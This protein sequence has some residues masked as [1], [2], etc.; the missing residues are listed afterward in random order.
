[1]QR[2][3]SFSHDV[4]RRHERTQSDLMV[5][6]QLTTDLQYFNTLAN[7]P[8][9]SAEYKGEI[10][11]ALKNIGRTIA[12]LSKRQ[13]DLRDATPEIPWA[14]LAAMAV[15]FQRFQNAQEFER[16]NQ[17]QMTAFT[18]ELG[19]L[20]TLVA[21]FKQQLITKQEKQKQLLVDLGSAI[22]MMTKY[23]QISA[24]LESLYIELNNIPHNLEDIRFKEQ[25]A[26]EIQRKYDLIQF[27][28]A[29]IEA[30]T[31]SLPESLQV[32][33]LQAEQA[34]KLADFRVKMDALLT[35]YNPKTRNALINSVRELNEM[36]ISDVL[37]RKADPNH[38][39]FTE[40]KFASV[41][42]K[43]SIVSTMPTIQQFMR[44]VLDQ[45]SIHLIIASIEQLS[46]SKM[47]DHKHFRAAILD[48]L[49]MFGEACKNFSPTVK[50]WLPGEILRS[51]SLLRDCIIHCIDDVSARQVLENLLMAD[52]EGLL[53]QVSQELFKLMPVLQSINTGTLSEPILMRCNLDVLASFS[54]K[55]TA[56]PSLITGADEVVVEHAEQ[57]LLHVLNHL[58][59]L[60]LSEEDPCLASARNFYVMYCG[61]L[62][63]TLEGNNF[64]FY[65]V[66]TEE[67]ERLIRE[68][69]NKRGEL[70]H[71][72]TARGLSSMISLMHLC[73]DLK[74]K[75]ES[76]ERLCTTMQT[77][78]LLTEQQDACFKL[79]AEYCDLIHEINKTSEYLTSSKKE[80][81][82]RGGQIL[83]EAWAHERES[84]V[85][86]AKQ[87]NIPI[88][89][90]A[91]TFVNVF[92]FGT[93]AYDSDRSP[94]K[95]QPTSTEYRLA[96]L[97]Q[98]PQKIIEAT[99]KK[100]LS[101]LQEKYQQLSDK[102]STLAD[103][104]AS[105]PTADG[106]TSSQE[107]IAQCK[108]LEASISAVLANLENIRAFDPLIQ[109]HYT[110]E[111]SRLRTPAAKANIREG[112]R[113]AGEFEKGTPSPEPA[114]PSKKARK[115]LNFS[116]NG[117]AEAGSSAG[118]SGEPS[119]ASV[120]T[121]AKNL[122]KHGIFSIQA[123]FDPAP[124]ITQIHGVQAVQAEQVRP[125]SS[126]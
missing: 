90:V 33:A 15:Y 117:R 6:A 41:I 115:A 68:I 59:E 50:Q 102:L 94:S 88:P 8:A 84:L 49:V 4:R 13:G 18:S 21:N 103:N 71:E 20:T 72:L 89:I 116:G 64:F 5:L 123:D 81:R 109:Q 55:L 63:R 126:T 24:V 10:F 99:V 82:N 96:K 69:T 11:T 124:T 45:D 7:L 104:L 44:G 36:F 40:C 43:R 37:Q 28:L 91:D 77:K 57:A 97:K 2:L 47:Q 79:V 101:D 19:Q 75:Q 66:A 65:S 122:A 93:A 80:T 100:Q 113:K 54:E 58:D 56:K 60:L 74:N 25:H 27:Y 3:V 120:E 31:A 125:V 32:F 73:S 121:P 78:S 83:R 52:P 86:L 46:T 106:D 95:L 119:P 118:S 12:D 98:S 1:M 14:E 105:F 112:L 26:A 70:A 67:I 87:D 108:A 42:G 85:A 23:Q 53:L 30:T 17:K 61:E 39:E 38:P 107:L 35:E 16:L 29:E 114:K 92:K 9:D 34:E 111:A 48:I 51:F 76:I 62:A 110:S 22:A